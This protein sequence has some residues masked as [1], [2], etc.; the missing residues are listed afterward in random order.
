[1]RL[2]RRSLS[3]GAG[4]AALARFA[5]P[6]ALAAEGETESHGL[7]IFGDLK[8]GPGFRHFDYVEPQAPKGGAFAFQIS[9]ITGNQNFDTFNTLNI[10][11]LRGDGAAGMWSG[12]DR[13]GTTTFDSLMARAFDE[14][15]A[16]YGLVAAAVR[17]S[18]DG[19]SYRFRLR[20]EARFHDGSK[21][22]A[23]DV[24]FSLTVLKEKGHP[25]IAQTIRLMLSAEAE[26][27]DVVVVKLAPERSRDLPLTIATL[28]IFS[29]A[30][31]R[32]R[33]FDAATLEAP[34]G[35]GPYKVG[36]LEVGRFIEFDRVADYW[37]RDLPVNIGHHN[38]ARIR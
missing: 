17:W 9:S 28:P 15:D 11:V 21:I 36:R 26:A 7:A 18:G 33:E 22:T 16:M 4:A 3:L 13:L 20:P 25:R 34:L 5:P 24:A 8:Y 29:Q 27:D 1:V 19:L 32:D 6:P 31:Y 2:T 35:S 30:Y 38:F 10:F 37:G 23:R 14:P 12:P